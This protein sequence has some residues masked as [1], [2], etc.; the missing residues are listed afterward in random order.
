MEDIKKVASQIKDITTQMKVDVEIQGKELNKIEQDTNIV[1]ENIVKT[2]LEIEE[3]EKEVQKDNRMRNI[4]L[5]LIVL[6]ITVII[7]VLILL[8]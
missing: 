7:T 5:L 1:N 8:K 4:K 6:V 2:E 3:A